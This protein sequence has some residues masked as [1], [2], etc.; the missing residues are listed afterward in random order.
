MTFSSFRDRFGKSRTLCAFAGGI[1]VPQHTAKK[2]RQRNSIA[3]EHWAS[4][5]AVAKRRGY[6]EITLDL[7]AGLKAGEIAAEVAE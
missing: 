1:G 4:V 3:S 5:V 2:I 6:G 7:L